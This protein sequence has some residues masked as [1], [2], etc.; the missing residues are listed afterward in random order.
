MRPLRSN[1]SLAKDRVF[2]NDTK[3]VLALAKNFV[4]MRDE[5]ETIQALLAEALVVESGHPGLTCPG[6]RYHEIAKVPAL[7]LSAKGFEHFELEGLRLDVDVD[8]PPGI[9]AS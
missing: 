3:D 8:R 2:E 7:S 4:A 6:R 9:G 1:V 5:E